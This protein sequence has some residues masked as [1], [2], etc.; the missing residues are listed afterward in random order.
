MFVD[1]LSVTQSS[2]QCSSVFQIAC[3]GTNCLSVLETLS[4]NLPS[5][6]VAT[7]LP[8]SHLQIH[9]VL[10]IRL[11]IFPRRQFLHAH[12]CLYSYFLPRRRLLLLSFSCCSSL[13]KTLLLP[14]LSCA[15]LLCTFLRVSFFRS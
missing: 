1:S 13:H 14:L 15:T 5:Y 11:G 8:T 9:C 6:W 10:L 4:C 2:C 12:S 3:I 7:L